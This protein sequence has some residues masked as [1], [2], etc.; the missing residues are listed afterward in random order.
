MAYRTR[1]YYTDAQKA[2]MWCRWQRGESLHTIAQL[3]DPGHSSVQGVLAAT[4]GIRPPEHRRSRLALTLAEQEQISRGIVAG[5]SN[6]SIENPADYGYLNG[7]NRLEC[8][9]PGLLTNGGNKA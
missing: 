9:I 2:E 1:I 5:S 7:N 3:F 4:G 6:C 8:D